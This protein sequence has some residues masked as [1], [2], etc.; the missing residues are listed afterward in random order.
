MPNLSPLADRLRPNNLAEFVGQKHIVPFIRDLIHYQRPISL[1]FW[2][3]PGTGKTTLA[4]II[5]GK[6]K[7]KF[8]HLSAVDSGVKEVRQVIKE[9]QN[10]KNFNGNQLFLFIDEIHHFNKKQQNSFLP[11]IEN[12]TIVLIGA[13]TENPS[14]SLISPLLSRCQV[15][16][17]EPLT[18]NNLETIIKRALKD[19][20]QGLGNNK[21]KLDK[22]GLTYLTN[23]SSGDARVALNILETFNDKKNLTLSQKDIEEKAK[24]TLVYDRAGDHH[25]DTISAFIKSIRGSNPDAALYYLARMLEAGEDPRFIARR[26]VILASEDISNANP[27]ALLVATSGASAVEFVG[28]PEAAISLAQMVTYLASSPKSN[29]SYMALTRAKADVKNLPL[30]PVPLDLR[31]AVTDMMADFKYGKN[32]KY[33]HDYKNHFASEMKFF[34]REMGEKIYYEPSDQGSEVKIGERLKNLRDQKNN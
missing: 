10:L 27:L 8:Y 15:L 1:I 7:G 16:K 31:N 18:N 26:L 5:A 20:T 24:K 23:L 28:L 12:G 3:P 11:Y 14:F 22:L 34:P 25:Y 17:F 4:Q 2:G 6:L 33:A 9:A 13:T 32:Y 21:I 30:Y 29:A 19:K